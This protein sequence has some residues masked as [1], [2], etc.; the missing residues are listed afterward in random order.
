MFRV[1]KEYKK[2]AEFYKYMIVFTA[3]VLLVAVYLGKIIT[4]VAWIIGI[5]FPFLLGLGFAFIFN[6]ISNALLMFLKHV[7]HIK[8]SKNKRTITN[9]VAI[10]LVLGVVA[11]F[12]ITIIPQVFMS[13]ERLVNNLPS[14]L[15]HLKRTALRMTHSIP[16]A[17][18]MIQDIN[19]YTINTNDILMRL[20]SLVDAFL[21][22]TKMVDQI[23]TIISTTISWFMTLF[24]SLAFSIF[25]LFNKARF[26]SDTKN[27][28]LAYLPTSGYK[29]G[30][31]IY[32]IF[33]RTFTR[34]IGG[35]LVECLILGGLVTVGSTILQIPYALLCGFLV[36]IGA[37][38][39]MFGALIVAICCS[40]FIM[41]QTPA[42]GLTFLIMFI[43]IQ[44]VEGNFIYPNVV[45][46]S[47]GFPP[48]YVI[49]AITLGAS[50]AGVIG[51]IIFI[52]LC[53]SLYQ[54]LQEYESKRIANKTY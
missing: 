22:D 42:A 10:M 53:S 36:S 2:R 39:P 1:P 7:F 37:L 50:I 28:F 4:F 20:N 6:L 16:S 35:T 8:P 5:L 9:I 49:V 54:L 33:K 19:I 31:H 23:N 43:A 11:V 12:F 47:V 52:P 15:A 26:I 24:L 34:Y 48:M 25:V 51:M 27:F 40:L 17:H 41:I 29:N 3:I 18:A 45:G 14:T 44:Q 38:V 32:Y 21:G 46:K 13:F 30:V